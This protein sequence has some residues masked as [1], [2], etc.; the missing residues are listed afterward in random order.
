[1]VLKVAWQ[2]STASSNHGSI[3]RWPKIR[4]LSS[5]SLLTFH[6]CPLMRFLRPAQ[7]LALAGRGPPEW[8]A[9]AQDYVREA[10]LSSCFVLT[11]AHQTTKL[12][13]S[14]PVIARRLAIH[15]S[16]LLRMVRNSPYQVSTCR[17][18]GKVDHCARVK[19]RASEVTYQWRIYTCLSS[20]AATI[21]RGCALHHQIH[22]I[23]S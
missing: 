23:S 4:I 17:S 2:A 22:Q 12:M 11:R 19:K 9:N 15:A 13:S 18:A 5:A 6:L 1:M 3:R 20:T 14:S 8:K 7:L 16:Q 10:P 21:T